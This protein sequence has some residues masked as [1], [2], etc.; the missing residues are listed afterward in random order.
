MYDE[1]TIVAEDDSIITSEDQEERVQSKNQSNIKKLLS[2]RKA[3]KQEIETLKQSSTK[4]EQLEKRLAEL[5][6]MIAGNELNKETDLYF[7]Q[8]AELNQFKT[9]I[10]DYANKYNLPLD[11]AKTLVL[12]K[13]NP[14]LLLDEQT[15]ARKLDNNQLV[16]W[17]WQSV[18]KDPMDMD[19]DEFLAYTNNLAKTG[20]KFK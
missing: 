6:D 20:K 12:A 18:E 19:D 3:M 17:V 4:A 7:A 14:T 5:E 13:T 1:E 10:V 11:E 9:D 2:E 16:S 8:N 15:R